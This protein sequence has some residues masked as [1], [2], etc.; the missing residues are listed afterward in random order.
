MNDINKQMVEITNLSKNIIT[1]MTTNLTPSILF[2]FIMIIL[3]VS[4]V[5]T[6]KQKLSQ[7]LIG[8]RKDHNNFHILMIEQLF[9]CILIMPAAETIKKYILMKMF[10]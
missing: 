5:L 9:V 8:N 4:F 7:S 10:K 2:N 6:F 3:S 1:K